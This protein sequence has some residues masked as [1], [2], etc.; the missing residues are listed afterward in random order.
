[1]NGQCNISSGTDPAT[2]YWH[3]STA[4][5]KAPLKSVKS[6]TTSVETPAPLMAPP[7]VRMLL[8]GA[9]LTGL[10]VGTAGSLGPA[11]GEVIAPP[12]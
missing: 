12:I 11:E 2:L 3:T 7:G 6:Q 4:L 5:P 9:L 1:M 10:N 8:V